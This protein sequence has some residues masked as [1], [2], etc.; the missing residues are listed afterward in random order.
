MNTQI[1]KPLLANLLIIGMVAACATPAPAPAPTAPPLPIVVDEMPATAPVDNTA[2]Y[3]NCSSEVTDLESVIQPI[4]EKMVSQQIP[5]TQNPANEWRDCSGNFL[6]LSSYLA[7][8][9]PESKA[10]LVAPPGIRDYTPG[11]N[12]V[13]SLSAN[14]RT[15]RDIAKW[16]QSQGNFTPIYYD[17]VS[18][19]SQVPDDLRNS[20]DL[21]RPGAVVW[22]SLDKPTAQDGVNGLFEKK[23]SRGPH[24]NHVATVTAVH[25]GE[26]GQVESFEMYHGRTRG[27]PGSVTKTHFWKWPDRYLHGGTREYPSFGYWKQ[28]LVGIAPIVPSVNTVAAN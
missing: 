15:S 2:Y 25:R 21:I 4:V 17:G 11:G 12:N 10:Y 7:T 5:Y 24:I 8:A 16:Y 22:F 6:R 9:C 14:A 13:A 1:V 3:A 19:P 18:S 27:K 28:Y 20:R 23:V 26:D